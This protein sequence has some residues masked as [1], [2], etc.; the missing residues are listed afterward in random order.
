M[1]GIVAWISPDGN[2][3][4]KLLA[5]MRDSIAH[6]GPDGAASWIGPHR[7]I[8]LGH[9]RLSIIDLSPI[10]DQP[11]SAP[12]KDAVL[13]FNGEI[14]N[15]AE[16]RKELEDEGV[17]FV[18]DHSDTEVILMGFLHWG[19][20]ELLNRLN[21]MFAF[22][23]YDRR[24]EKVYAVRDR[25]GIKPLYVTTVN[26]ELLFGSEIKA[27]LAHPKVS[28]NLNHDSFV[29]YLTF[30]ATAAPSTLFS[31]IECLAAGELLEYDIRSRTIARRVWWDPLD[32]CDEPPATYAE[33]CER[34]EELLREAIDYRMIADV[35]VGL[36]LS[37]GVDSGFLL[38][39][40]AKK[41]SSLN[42]YT[43]VYEDMGR[44]NEGDDA[45]MLAE[46]AHTNHHEIQVTS[47]AFSDA[48][49][50][51]AY[52]Q[53]EPIAA[54]VCSSV[55][56]LSKKTRDTG[57]KVV[58]SGEGADEIF[59]G[60]RN[61]M[62]LR[63][64][65]KWNSWL[66]DFPGRP[67]RKAASAIAGSL[68]PWTSA[69]R[70]IL[71]RAANGQPL[72]WG[73]SLDFGEQ[74]KSSLIGPAIKSD[75]GRTF[76]SVVAPLHQ[77][78]LQRSERRDLTAWMSYIDLKFRL[79]QLMLP[80][81]DKMGM[82]FSIEGRVPFLDHRIIE[83]VLGLPPQWRGA[84]GQVGKAIFKK[85]A[86][87]QLPPEYVYR[88]KRGFQAPVKEWRSSE[89][90]QRYLPLLRDFARRTGLLNAGALERL[91]AEKDSRLYYSLVNLAVW[92]QIYIEGDSELRAP[93]LT[94]L[95]GKAA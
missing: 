81:L 11:M 88:E 20:E 66:P 65:E 78:F 16:L 6:R 34:L 33:A 95:V 37:G 82:A 49:P 75:I 9:R 40:M 22:V 50:S 44:Y 52:H 73:G 58:L 77:Q 76:D 62:R 79:P 83:F 70:E 53:D 21:G 15:H 7:R 91:L 87:K 80:R 32:H 10:A 93:E 8:G 84:V 42:T 25:V 54:P 47:S 41:I 45:R 3:E 18:T 92:H 26:G 2:V 4:P 55:Y 61:W 5:E 85:I 38:Q 56:F 72:F 74:I 89:F 39:S 23:I 31:G 86:S 13:V 36:F 29:D 63:D 64:A 57:V 27:I 30:R 14:Y 60:Y 46:R 35:P 48:F 94:S 28:R 24:N 12:N 68:L 17:R 69:G 51:V 1:C 59:I 43:I 67:I 71:R 90:G 19:L